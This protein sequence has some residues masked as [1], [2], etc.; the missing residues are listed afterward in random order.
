MFDLMVLPQTTNGLFMIV[1]NVS[2]ELIN[3]KAKKEWLLYWQHFSSQ[4]SKYCSQVNCVAESSYGVL[5]K[6]PDD[7]QQLYVIPLCKA[8]SENFERSLEITEG[9]EVIPVDLTL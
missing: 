9:T 4:H 8:H 1:T 5:V 6:T 2:D 3:D 7:Q